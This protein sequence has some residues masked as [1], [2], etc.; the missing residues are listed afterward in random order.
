MTKAQF[1]SNNVVISV[2]RFL[3]DF[4]CYRMFADCFQIYA[5]VAPIKLLLKFP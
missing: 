4:T 5:E 3:A 2:E 1:F